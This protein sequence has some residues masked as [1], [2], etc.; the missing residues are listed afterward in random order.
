[1]KKIIKYVSIRYMATGDDNPAHDE[2]TVCDDHANEFE[3]IHR[4]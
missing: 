2:R 1:M 3:M 4:V